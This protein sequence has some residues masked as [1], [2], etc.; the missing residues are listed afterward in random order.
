MAIPWD[1]LIT[2]GSTLVA[3][4][5]GALGG[6]GLAGRQQLQRDRQQRRLDAY[7]ELALR[8]DE[9][10]R[11][12]GAPQT[13]T[14]SKLTT[15]LGSS[16]GQAVGAVQ[17]A[18]FAVYLSGSK[19]LQPLAGEA[20]QAAWNIQNWFTNA[21]RQG[22]ASKSS[23]TAIKARTEPRPPGPASAPEPV[24]APPPRPARH[25]EPEAANSDTKRPIDQLEELRRKLGAAGQKFAEAAR[26]ELA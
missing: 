18:Y 2:A 4:V 10:N 7:S 3:G 25:E 13:L 24:P 22:D 11:T 14:E 23:G 5:G 19:K 26:K 8:L 17:V 15:T 9:L 12:L 1:L 20:W 21:S 6:A 16:V